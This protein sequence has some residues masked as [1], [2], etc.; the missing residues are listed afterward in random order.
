MT[1]F[2]GASDTARER[3]FVQ[4]IEPVGGV[5]ELPVCVAIALL[6]RVPGAH[7][8]L[9]RHRVRLE[10]REVVGWAGEVDGIAI[11]RKDGPRVVMAR[12][13]GRQAVGILLP[14]RSAPCW[15]VRA[16]SALA[17]GP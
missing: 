1:C 9:D 8:Q 14:A 2:K 17:P 7:A 12:V 11:R 5:V 4:W 15:A 3:E 13:L 6:Q 10:V 16:L